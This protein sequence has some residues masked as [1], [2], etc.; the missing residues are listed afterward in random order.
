RLAWDMTMSSFGSRQTHY[1]YYF[2]GD[3]VKMGMAYFD[4]YNKEPYKAMVDKF[5]ESQNIKKPSILTK[6]GTQTESV[7]K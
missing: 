7:L 3:P 5:L 6:S 4:N 2:F 1:E